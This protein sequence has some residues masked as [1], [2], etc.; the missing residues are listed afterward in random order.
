MTI[1]MCD[2]WEFG[3]NGM[4]QWSGSGSVDFETS[5]TYRS[6]GAAKVT[7]VG[8]QSYSVPY[9]GVASGTGNW[10]PS[11]YL[12]DFYDSTSYEIRSVFHMYISDLP[13]TS[14]VFHLY[15]EYGNA[16]YRNRIY[17]NPDGTIGFYN[18]GSTS[19]STW[20]LSTDQWY[21]VEIYRSGGS[22]GA[23]QM[24]L[25]AW[26]VPDQTLVGTKQSGAWVANGNE[27]TCY[28]GSPL[29]GDGTVIFDNWV[30]SL[31]DGVSPLTDLDTKDYCI[32]RLSVNGQGVYNDSDWSGTYADVDDIPYDD[33]TSYRRI[34][35]STQTG[36]FSCT[37]EFIP[38]VAVDSIVAVQ[39]WVRHRHPTG[40]AAT[41]R[42]GLLR[43]GST[44]SFSAGYNTATS[45]WNSF[46]GIFF[47]DPN[48]STTWDASDLSSIEVGYDRYTVPITA[49]QKDVTAIGAYVLMIPAPDVFLEAGGSGVSMAPYMIV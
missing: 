27:S 10:Q 21:C 4:L 38:A 32:D 37:V 46:G 42:R 22:G 14:Y 33:A 48:T 17:I 43:S 16:Q 20:S 11:T 7:L 26:S 12:R 39:Y 40:T 28:L 19:S 8:G 44:D 23:S 6:H 45:S 1:E 49:N 5:T 34:S 29:G 35:G 13:S 25:T 31:D 24:T 47:N 3:A 36:Y 30:Y 41:Q 18:N 2:G 9:C 15:G